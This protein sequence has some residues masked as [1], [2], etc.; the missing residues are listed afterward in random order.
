MTFSLTTLSSYLQHYAHVKHFRVALSGGLDSSV[1]LHAVSSLRDANS[2]WSMSAI[3]VHHGLN[4]KADDW[5]NFCQRICQQLQ[6]PCEIVHVDASPVLGESPEA[7][8]R[9]LRYQVLADRINEGDALLTAHHQN[10]QAETLLLQLMRGCGLP[11]LAAMPSEARFHK[12]LLLRPL[13]SFTREH[14]LQYAKEQQL[15]WVDDDSN[16][17]R[18]YD[19]NY[20]RHEIMPAL[21]SRWPGATSS[22][23]RTALH[24]AEADT[25]LDELA[26]IDLQD[27]ASIDESVI[28]IKGLKKLSAARQRNVLRCWLR[29]LR[30]A[31]PSAVKMQHILTDV[32]ES[33][34][35][36]TPCVSWSEV[37]IRRYRDQL[38]AIPAM[39]SIDVDTAQQWDMTSTLTMRGVGTLKA[40]S[41]Q[42]AGLSAGLL[43]SKNLSVRFR[44]GGERIQLP[45]REHQHELKKLFQQS[46]IPPWVRDRTPLLYQGEALIAVPGIGVS[47]NAMSTQGQHGLQLEWYR[48]FG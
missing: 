10:D 19:R 21:L 4:A 18:G 16:D 45:G 26:V 29:G 11:G 14:L 20:L 3:H 39:S 41:I 24:I 7:I 48:Q 25:L 32:I 8:A 30:L 43:G 13:L 38:F 34:I 33:K 5:A 44:Q 22:L 28:D 2:E 42:G 12:G 37:E 15:E 36:S 31:V 1:L 9:K 40:E 23:S 35:D 46:G 47:A 6:V 17:D 27:L